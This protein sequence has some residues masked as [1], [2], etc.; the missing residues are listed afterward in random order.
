MN[1]LVRDTEIATMNKFSSDKKREVLELAK[2]IISNLN[3]ETKSSLLIG[4]VQSGKTTT[5]INVI[6]AALNSDFQNVIVLT[7]TK[8]DLNDQTF[9]RIIKTFDQQISYATENDGKP[10]RINIFDVDTPPSK[11]ELSNDKYKKIIVSK[12]GAST[13]KIVD[14]FGYGK[15]LIID[16]E[17]DHASND[18]NATKKD[19]KR[20]TT[21]ELLTRIFESKNA[22]Y[23]A[24]TATPQSHSLMHDGEFNRPSKIFFVNAGDGYKGVNDFFEETSPI[25][26]LVPEYEASKIKEGS[27]WTVD[28][29]VQAIKIALV[30]F[31]IKVWA[32]R[33][34]VIVGEGVKKEN[35][36]FENFNMMVNVDLA[37]FKQEQA[38]A[39]IDDFLNK[40]LNKQND[41]LE[42]YMSNK[43]VDELFEE[44]GISETTVDIA[45]KIKKMGRNSI[46]IILLNKDSKNKNIPPST[47]NIIIGGHSLSRGLTIENLIITYFIQDPK[48]AVAPTTLQRARWFGYR[49]KY[50]KFTRLF[51]T[52]NIL[53]IF[54]ELMDV[55][56]ILWD[57]ASQ[58]VEHSVHGLREVFAHYSTVLVVQANIA[59]YTKNVK[60][61]VK[62]DSNFG[63]VLNKTHDDAFEWFN[64]NLKDLA[65]RE[66]FEHGVYISN[67]KIRD[68]LDTIEE[69][70]DNSVLGSIKNDLEDLLQKHKQ[71]RMICFFNADDQNSYRGSK[72][73]WDIETKYSPSGRNKA[74][75]LNDLDY[76]LDEKLP[77]EY[78]IPDIQFHPIWDKKTDQKKLFF[79]V[80]KENSVQN[81]EIIHDKKD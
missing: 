48:K 66:S 81:L 17:S 35:Q 52:R 28:K 39:F 14:L 58:K 21:N 70:D 16:D 57:Y 78:N 68:I 69:R 7:G 12:K 46:K 27:D 51:I 76:S 32:L 2:S 40:L 59:K 44:L 22:Y 49:N 34:G 75:K 3:S 79:A 4:R 10:F 56:N 8:N 47:S 45:E 74:G 23:L 65:D 1:N 62:Y 63:D 30:E 73:G 41:F 6:A 53:T 18:T 64:N 9:E 29:N 54:K 20:S 67:R 71:I 13:K 25:I 72:K 37:N 77:E 33:E 36:M 60:G 80:F 55:E 43:F 11:E 24:V 38:D 31:L 19:G 15:T 5:F 61:F 50:F 26:R 42:R